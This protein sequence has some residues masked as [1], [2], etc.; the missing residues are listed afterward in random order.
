MV[1]VL[2]VLAGIALGVALLVGGRDTPPPQSDVRDLP[3]GPIVDRP[4]HGYVVDDSIPGYEFTDGL[5]DLRLDGDAPATI[6]A[7]EMDGHGFE[8]VG[9]LVAGPGINHIRQKFDHFPPREDFPGSVQ[10]ATGAV[11]EPSGA[12]P[13]LMDYELLIGLRVTTDDVGVRQGLWL[14]YHIRD[15]YY[16]EHRNAQI[17]FCPP[18]RNWRSCVS[19]AGISLD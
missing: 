7:I 4:E 15:R 6:D 17:V 3:N 1:A 10:S 14:R 8:V 11:L 18:D 19:E 2:A 5:E 13:G 16:S 9:A 12:G